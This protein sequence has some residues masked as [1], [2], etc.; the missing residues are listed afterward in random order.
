MLKPSSWS[1]TRRVLLA[2]LPVL[3]LAQA[4]SA[5]VLEHRIKVS[6]AASGKVT[7]RWNLRVAIETA[8]D[9]ADWKTYA[10]Y[11]DDNRRLVSLEGTVILPNGGREKI[12]RKEQ[13]V[14]Q[15]AGGGILHSSARYQIVEPVHLP[16]GSTLQLLYS[17]ETE[18]YWPGGILPLMPADEAIDN[19][20]LSV[21]VDPAAGPLHFRLDGPAEGLS[22]VPGAQSVEVRGSLPDPEPLPELAGG[23]SVREPVLRYA[24]GEEKSWESLGVWYNGLLR[25][26]PQNTPEVQKLAREL[27]AGATTPRAK[28]EA[29]V[30]HV[31]R[32]V[33]Y[34]A[35]EI[36][37][38][39]YRPHAPADVAKK[40]WGDCKDKSLLLID[41]ARAVG[42]EAWP[43]L[44]RLD[45]SG[46]IDRE[47]PSPY[48]F[49][50]AITAF[51]AAPLEV[52]PGDPVADGF[53]FID[54][55]QEIGQA[56]Y[57]HQGVQD[58]DAVVVLAEKGQLVR[59]PSQPATASRKLVVELK[60]AADG[61]AQGRARAELEGDG[62]ASLL[63]F[64]D[65]AASQAPLEDVLR[66]LFEAALRG[67]RLQGLVYS[68]GQ[69]Q[70]PRFETATLVEHPAYLEGLD[71][72]GSLQ[73]GGLRL[74]PEPRDIEKI[75]KLKAAAPGT[76]RLEQIYIFEL[77]PGLCPPEA[78]EEK[79]ENA[80]GSLT[81]T[82]EVQEGKVILKRVAE[83]R[84]PWVEQ[85]DYPALSELAIAE[86]R[87][88]QRRIRFGCKG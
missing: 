13:D 36:G 46:R 38:G 37:I 25:S 67:A 82:L 18:P 4:G 87:A 14:A 72:G 6:V 63:Q 70:L 12:G 22:V 49:N 9:A 28:L 23:G 65:A 20:Q 29:L 60:L 58:Q 2:A 81:T 15:A 42:L 76:G 78:K 5:R 30:A 64:L 86:T 19:I 84:R 21:R 79:T 39:G 88:L 16:T 75:A 40:L 53:F 17:L 10:I 45:E 57:L 8:E 31:R 83:L 66:R 34:V 80:I 77:P 68:A 51:A 27:T 56:G 32:K 74:F 59:L 85:A 35:V 50:H 69:G 33:R 61:S 7:E 55:T 54:P 1:A 24:W 62:A 26:V 11:L 3:F 47:F 43:V 44:I 71:R 52:K 41:L 48:Q 73:A